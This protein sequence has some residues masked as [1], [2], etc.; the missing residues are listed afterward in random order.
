MGTPIDDGR[1]YGDF[2]DRVLYKEGTGTFKLGRHGYVATVNKP[3]RG[4]GSAL[5]KIQKQVRMNS[6]RCYYV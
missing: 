4:E 5:E 2:Q 1:Q 6:F 3:V